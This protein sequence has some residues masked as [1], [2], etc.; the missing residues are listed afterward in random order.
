MKWYH[1]IQKLGS[2]CVIGIPSNLLNSKKIYREYMETPDLSLLRVGYKEIRRIL[3]RIC[4][5]FLALPT[6][7]SYHSS[8]RTIW[9]CTVTSTLCNCFAWT[10]QT[11]TLYGRCPCLVCH[12]KSSRGKN[13]YSAIICCCI[14]LLSFSCVGHSYSLCSPRVLMEGAA[15]TSLSTTMFQFRKICKK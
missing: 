11:R 3:W 14:I 6:Q 13:W 7:H 5:E 10:Q 1:F 12:P 15:Y 8:Q 2:F 9:T 4:L